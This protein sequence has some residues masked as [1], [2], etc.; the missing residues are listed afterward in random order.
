M[1][2]DTEKSD[3]N[4]SEFEAGAISR[5]L[6]GDPLG[7]KDGLLPPLAK[8]MVEAGKSAPP[9]QRSPYIKRN[10]Q[11]CILLGLLLICGLGNALF[12]QR[13]Q[14][15][16]KTNLLTLPQ[17]NL[18]L[19]FETHP[20][21]HFGI[22]LGASTQDGFADLGGLAWFRGRSTACSIESFSLMTGMTYFKPLKP[23]WEVGGKLLYQYRS[24]FVPDESCLSLPPSLGSS[25][26]FYARNS[27][28]VNLMP[29]LRFFATKHLF[30]EAALGIGFEK[31]ELN[32]GEF[33]DWYGYMPAQLN[34]GIKF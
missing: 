21:D 9:V 32:S 4:Y 19:E 30:L 20:V 5:L 13:P 22:V 25:R 8:R 23:Q 34:L 26:F 1:G 2:K 7:G 18:A 14:I 28:S 33:T 6:N 12:A 24:T 17:R 31:N 15:L 11:K 3:F 16:I 10:M 27:H 29:M